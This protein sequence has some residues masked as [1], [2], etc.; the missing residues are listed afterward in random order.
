MAL[1]FPLASISTYCNSLQPKGFCNP[2]ITQSPQGRNLSL[3][4][5]KMIYILPVFEEQFLWFLH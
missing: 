5:L 1:I 3:H 2:L 4:Y